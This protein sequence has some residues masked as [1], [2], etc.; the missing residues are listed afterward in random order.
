MQKRP[1]LILVLSLVL[2]PL[3]QLRAQ[4]EGAPLQKALATQK[5]YQSVK[6]DFVLIKESPAFTEKLSTPGKLWLL[7]G[8]AFRWELGNPRT[9]TIIYEGQSVYILDETNQTGKRHEPDDKEVKPLLLTLGIGEDATY[10]G[11]LNLFRISSTSQKGDRFVANLSPTNRRVRRAITELRM[12]INTKTSFPE[13]IGW[14][15]TDETKV[16][17]KFAKPKIN[18]AMSGEIFTFDSGAYRW[19]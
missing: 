16:L 1:P 2:I 13:E 19:E 8:R 6:V 12:Q 4:N 7:P 3:S 17:T 18:I 14:T 5:G 9:Q 15:Q 10:E 11:L